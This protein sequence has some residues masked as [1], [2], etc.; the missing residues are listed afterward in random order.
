MISRILE[1]LFSPAL[2][3]A[4]DEFRMPG[5]LAFY[6]CQS[7]LDPLAKDGF[8]RLLVDRF[9]G[10]VM[11]PRARSDLYKSPQKPASNLGEFRGANRDTCDCDARHGSLSRLSKR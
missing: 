11:Y 6:E 10:H 9:H 7:D 2:S 8:A 3:I 1:R 4:L 5:E